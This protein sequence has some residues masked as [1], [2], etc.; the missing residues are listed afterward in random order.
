MIPDT[1]TPFVLEV[2]STPL[3]YGGVL[4]QTKVG[5]LAPVECVSTTKKRVEH[6]DAEGT[7]A[8]TLYCLC[9]LSDVVAVAAQIEMRTPTA[10]LEHLVAMM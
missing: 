4:L 7:L 9:K 2:C 5:K 8:A 6:L 10:S 1:C 3:G